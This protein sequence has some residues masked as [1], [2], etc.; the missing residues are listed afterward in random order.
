M[1][2]LLLPYP[3]YAVLFPLL[4]FIPYDYLSPALLTSPYLFSFSRLSL[5]KSPN[6]D[7]DLLLDL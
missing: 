1:N 3:N 4:I 5:N 7:L 2:T 6:F